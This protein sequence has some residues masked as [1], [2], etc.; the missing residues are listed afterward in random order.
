MD[1]QTDNH[2]NSNMLDDPDGEKPDDK[3]SSH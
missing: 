3:V 2:V 1:E